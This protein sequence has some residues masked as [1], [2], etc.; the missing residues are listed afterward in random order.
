MNAEL[1]PDLNFS[2]F[3]S[4]RTGNGCFGHL[5]ND[6]FHGF[7]SFH[8]CITFRGCSFLWDLSSPLPQ[9][10]KKQ[11][12]LFRNQSDNLKDDWVRRVLLSEALLIPRTVLLQY[13]IS[14][15]SPSLSTFIWIFLQPPEG[16]P[17][18]LATQN[19]FMK[20]S[21]SYNWY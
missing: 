20:C 15:I 21:D 2:Q 4:C 13:I 14:R 6:I 11:F 9:A 10:V 17:L 5:I 3:W 1:N 16:T 7:Y 12:G 18:N 8:K 19:V